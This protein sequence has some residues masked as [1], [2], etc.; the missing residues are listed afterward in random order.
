M[1]I[2]ANQSIGSAGSASYQYSQAKLRSPRSCSARRLGSPPG[3]INCTSKKKKMSLPKSGRSKK[4]KRRLAS[5]KR[6]K[7]GLYLKAQH[8]ATL[9]SPL[10]SQDENSL[11]YQPQTMETCRRRQSHC[12]CLHLGDLQDA[13]PGS[14]CRPRQYDHSE[15][16]RHLRGLI[17][18][19]RETMREIALDERVNRI[20]PS[21]CKDEVR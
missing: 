5:S 4:S 11:L 3:S 18:K 13:R 10:R 2:Q 17:G 19:C 6:S 20:S 15:P 1:N 14:C 7:S 21:R 8:G 16:R 12:Q 9:C